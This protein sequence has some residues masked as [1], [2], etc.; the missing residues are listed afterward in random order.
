MEKRYLFLILGIL[1]TSCTS[2]FPKYDLDPSID[3]STYNEYKLDNFNNLY[4]QEEDIYAVYV[5]NTDC[6][7][8]NNL[9]NTILGYLGDYKNETRRLKVYLYNSYRL[10]DENIDYLKELPSNYSSTSEYYSSN[11]ISTVK[12]TLVESV[13]SLF[14]IKFNTL[15]EYLEG[16]EGPKYLFN[17]TFDSRSYDIIK[18]YYIDDLDKFYSLN[19]K[20]YAIYLYFKECPFCFSIRTYLYD[21]L[22]N[23]HSLDIYVFDM[24][25]FATDEGKNN[26]SKFNYISNGNLDDFKNELENALSNNVN[27]VKNTPFKY[28]PSLYYVKN[29]KLSNVIYG[30]DDIKNVLIK[31]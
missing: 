30:S 24:K 22:L 25:S 31:H 4:S 13:P 28:V 20:E 23:D 7:I 29:N 14:V 5:Y 15:Y 18:D 19:N 8:C 21:Y 6:D 3:Y 10:K 1:L 12:D 2:I 16:Y 17:N 26:R 11:T 27:E 9:K